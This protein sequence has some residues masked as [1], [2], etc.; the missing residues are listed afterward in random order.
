MTTRDD[1]VAELLRQHGRTFAQQAGITRADKPSPLYRLL[2]L[3][4][5]LLGLAVRLLGLPAPPRGLAG[6]VSAADLPRLTA[7]CVRATHED[8]VR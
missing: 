3:A 7:L 6:L 8:D 1:R 5:R 2:V 4:V